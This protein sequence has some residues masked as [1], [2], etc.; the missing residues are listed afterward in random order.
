VANLP[1]KLAVPIELQKLR[2]SRAISGAGGVAAR[3]N[4]NMT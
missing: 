2:R 1:K 3:E 4:E